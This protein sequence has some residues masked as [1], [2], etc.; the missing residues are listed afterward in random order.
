MAIWHSLWLIAL[1]HFS[2]KATLNSRN[3]F[4]T[5]GSSKRF[6]TLVDLP[7][8]VGVL[9]WSSVNTLFDGLG[10]LI[11]V[12]VVISTSLEKCNKFI[13]DPQACW[14]CSESSEGK[15]QSLYFGL[16]SKE[17]TWT[18]LQSLR[19]RH[20]SKLHDSLHWAMGPQ[21]G[22][23]KSWG[24]VRCSSLKQINIEKI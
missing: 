6:A 14:F 3:G 12:N 4:D 16:K 10:E 1:I 2:L 8:N 5:I 24:A 22:E 17:L 7:Q 18:L 19:L 13:G 11:E 21:Q 9:G 20:I 23:Q 15:M